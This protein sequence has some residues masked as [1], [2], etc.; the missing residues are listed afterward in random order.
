[1]TCLQSIQMFYINT[2]LP[3][4]FYASWGQVLTIN[5]FILL[6]IIRQFHSHYLNYW[7]TWHVNK[8]RNEKQR[9]FLPHVFAENVF[10]F[11]LIKHFTKPQMVWVY[12]FVATLNSPHKSSVLKMTREMKTNKSSWGNSSYY[13]VQAILIKQ[14]ITITNHSPKHWLV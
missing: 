2:M 14:T 7:F 12:L 5:T 6:S 13:L 4:I 8:G 11:F 3:L 10:P 9:G 1:M